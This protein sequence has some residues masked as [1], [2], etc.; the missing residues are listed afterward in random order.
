MFCRLAIIALLFSIAVPRVC[1]SADPTAVL[2]AIHA[3]QK[4]GVGNKAAT[5]AVKTLSAAEADAIPAVLKGFTGAS[6]LAANYLRS[7]VEAI[8]DRQLADGAKLPAGQIEE[9]VWDRS[10]DP[11]AR[12]LGYEL[13]LRVDKSAEKRI[14][15][16]MLLDPS[17]EFRRDA[18]AR[19]I[20]MADEIS[21]DPAAVKTYQQALSGA[22]D[23]DQV[24]HIAAAL[25]KFGKDVDLAGHYGFLTSW[26]IIGPFNNEGLVGFD[27]PSPPEEK[28]DLDAKLAGQRGE[29]AWDEIGTEHAYGILDIAKSIA[30]HKGAVMYLTTTFESGDADDIQFRFG[31]PNAWKIWLNGELLFGRD[32]YH[33]GM[34]IDQY[35]VGGKLKAGRN[36]ILVKLCQN[37]QKD[38]WAQ[39]YQL[40]LRVCHSSGIAVHQSRFSAANTL[41][42]KSNVVAAAAQTQETN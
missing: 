21:A 15:P 2:K 3:V 4:E 7:A 40:Q 29:V 30:P 5:Q 28:L 26:R 24:K 6:P 37:E 17:P 36:V 39:R 34:G 13:L 9:L 35:Q 18:V 11:R 19:L 10:A 23:S 1:E 22:T 25:K 32:E 8:A 27:K 12:R 14:I 31:T 16:E 33:R 38:S 42:R 20:M 41:R